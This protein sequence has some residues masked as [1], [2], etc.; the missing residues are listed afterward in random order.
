MTAFTT[1]PFCTCPSGEASF[2]LAVITSPRPAR[3]PVE[4]PSGRI[5]C[6][7]RAP[8]LSATSSIVLIITAIAQS[9]CLFA[10]PLRGVDSGNRRNFRHQRRFAY[11]FFQA[12]PLQLRQWAGFLKPHHIAHVGF[13]LLVVRVEL[14]VG[15]DD[16][17]I[18]RVRLLARHRDHDGLVHLVGDDFAHDFL[19]P[20]RR[21]LCSFRHYFFSVVACA[22]RERSPTMVF[23]RAMS[24]RRPR[25]FFRLSVWPMLS[26]NFSLNSWSESCR[27]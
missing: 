1:F 23:T 14:L 13:V 17:A 5:I 15:G 26:W 24:L 12:P 9:P 2:T 8:E 25:I 20:S 22:P 16:A 4:P 11:D 19:A 27:S 18:E 3:R 21:L 10:M 7:L 6:S